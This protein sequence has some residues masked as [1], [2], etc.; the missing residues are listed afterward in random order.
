MSDLVL[1]S[2][3]AVQND[4][5]ECERQPLRGEPRPRRRGADG[6]FIPGPTLTLLTDQTSPYRGKISDAVFFRQ[7]DRG[8]PFHEGVFAELSA[9]LGVRVPGLRLHSRFFE[10][11]DPTDHGALFEFLRSQIARLRREF[12]GRKLIVHVSPGTP[13]MHTVWVL[14]AETGF[15]GQ[16]FETVKSYR[17]DERRGR[18]AVVP[19][20]LGIDTYYKRYTEVHTS[21]VAPQEQELRWDPARFRSPVLKQLYSEA[22]RIARLR[23]P[24]LILGERGAGKTT[25]AGWI[26][27]ASSFR[28]VGLDRDWPAVACG[29]YTTET[30][31]AELFGYR[32][33]SFTGANQ[34]RQGL[35][36]HADGD[37]VFLDEIGDVSRDMQRLLLKAIEENRFQPLGASDYETSNFRLLTA[38]NLSWHDL[39]ERLDADFLDRISAFVLRVPPLR[40]IR[41]DLDW[42]WDGVL[43]IAAKRAEV[44][45]RYAQLGKQPREKILHALR[46]H[47]L[48]ANLRNLFQ[49]AW[50]LLAARYDSEEPL[51]VDEAVAD[52]LQALAP[53]DGAAPAREAGLARQVARAF[54]EGR[55]LDGLMPPD[56]FPTTKV[57]DGLR[58]YL[59]DELR[60]IV[61]LRGVNVNQIADVGARTLRDWARKK[62]AD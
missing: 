55:Q 36:K 29:Q 56:H 45:P 11:D 9:E 2:W 42:M 30:M 28:K 6:A 14:M 3:V 35:L 8:T 33:D 15:I 59:S 51:S 27:A 34:N 49:V 41:E 31:R 57:L 54:A 47:Q 17:P 43:A 19:V 58:A 23:V 10:G 26:R 7:V 4:P 24:V 39:Q 13:S 1:L 61:R 62:T 60:R 40:E 32:K 21:Q 20:Q 37:T 52:A 22:R 5:F 44:P 50:R 48:P 16:P 38:T 53:H 12:A 18:D 46:T 25:L